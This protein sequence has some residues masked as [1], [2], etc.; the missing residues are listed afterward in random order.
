MCCTI[1][2]P[3]VCYQASGHQDHIHGEINI[4]GDGLIDVSLVMSRVLATRDVRSISHS[5]FY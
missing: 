1:V 5:A 2:L 4:N 3:G